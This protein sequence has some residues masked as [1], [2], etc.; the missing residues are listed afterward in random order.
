MCTGLAQSLYRCLAQSMLKHHGLLH[1]QLRATTHCDWSPVYRAG[2]I[3][4]SHPEKAF[5]SGVLRLVE[6]EKGSSKV[7]KLFRYAQQLV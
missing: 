6:V 1:T 4:S 7:L 3:D 2:R 5:I